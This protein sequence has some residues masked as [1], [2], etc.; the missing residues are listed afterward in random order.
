MSNFKPQVQLLR[1]LPFGIWTNFLAN[2]SS[3][4][5]NAL[6]QRF[7]LDFRKIM[8]SNFFCDIAIDFTRSEA[9]GWS[10]LVQFFSGYNSSL[11]NL[12][13]VHSGRV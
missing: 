8:A 11:L 2:D 1:N 4:V 6:S 12:E 3:L 13:K 10:R 7:I 9:R 5:F